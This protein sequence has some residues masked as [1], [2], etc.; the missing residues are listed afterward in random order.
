MSDGVICALKIGVATI[1]ARAGGKENTCKV[2]VI[3]TAVSRVILS[4]TSL[5]LKAGQSEKLSATVEP[6]DATDKAITWTSSDETVATV[7]DG[8]VSAVKVGAASIIA[9]CGNASASCE[10]QVTPIEVTSVILNET[11]MSLAVGTSASL[12]ATV[13]PDD[14][15]DKTV[16]WSST[17]DNV[18]VVIDGHVNA[19]GVGNATIIAKSGNQSARC[20]IEVYAIPATGISISEDYIEMI[21]GQSYTLTAAIIP[22]NATDKTIIWT[23][24]NTSVARVVDGNV[25]AVGQGDATISASSADKKFKAEC[26]V[27]V[28]AKA[29]SIKLSRGSILGYLNKTYPI[30]VI[31]TP[32][33]AVCDIEW[34]TSNPSIANVY[35]QSGKHAEIRF[36]SYFPYDDGATITAYDRLSGLSTSIQ[37]CYFVRDFTW[38]EESKDAYLSFP[39]ITI[40]IGEKHQLKY[41]HSS[42]SV[43]NLFEDLDNFVIYES[44][45]VQQPTHIS[46]DEN[47]CV[48]GL[49]EGITGLKATGQIMKKSGGVDRVY[50]KV[51]SSYE[52][53]EP[54]NDFPY[55]TAMKS[56]CPMTFAL[57][58]TSDVDI[59]KF[60]NPKNGAINDEFGIELTYNGTND[61]TSKFLRYEV[62]SS[63]YALFGSG[64][65]SVSNKG[66]TVKTSAWLNTTTGYIKFY[67]PP[68]YIS[69][70]QTCPHSSFTLEIK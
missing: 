64:T 69:Y 53:T 68:Q 26:K 18:A 6:D 49:T 51:V 24:S 63:N 21:T 42:V 70:P 67:F 55:A 48:T 3:P 5:S 34:R 17:N 43:T 16:S 22:D 36:S 57:S 28:K 27:S 32:E 47:G 39:L 10:V 20:E 44:S 59:I 13:S 45:V 60:T 35:S 33:D 40:M 37:V 15:T 56:G 62:Y 11:S 54:N 25:T 7:N 8:V 58:S 61:G 65:F 50:I 1:T 12:T 46:I 2:E 66:E 30:E 4:K 14:A 38:A 29:A 31:T 23:S 52:E 19:I 9:K 41:T